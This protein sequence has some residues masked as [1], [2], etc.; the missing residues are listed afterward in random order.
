MFN[1]LKIKHYFC[2]NFK[3]QN[4]SNPKFLIFVALLFCSLL[5]HSQILVLKTKQTPPFKINETIMI[6]AYLQNNTSKPIIYYESKYFETECVKES[7]K[8]FV[9]GQ[10]VELYKFYDGYDKS[11]FESYINTLQPGLKVPLRFKQIPLKS[12]G[13]YVIEYT[14]M[15]SPDLIVKSYAKT[16]AAYEKSRRITPFDIYGKFEFDVM[17]NKY[18]SLNDSAQLSYSNWLSLKKDKDFIEEKSYYSMDSAVLH[19]DNVFI[20]TIN[21]KSPNDSILKKIGTFKNLK[22]L[23][24]YFNGQI[25]IPDEIY[26]LNLFELTVQTSKTDSIEFSEKISELDSLRYLHI[27]NVQN[28]PEN[29]TNLPNL[30]LLEIAFCKIDS[31]PGLERF[32]KLKE[33]SFTNLNLKT[34]EGLGLEK[35]PTLE[36]VSFIGNEELESMLPL[37]KCTNL[38]SVCFARCGIKEV[39]PEIENLKLLRELKL[40][41]NKLTK[42]DPNIGNLKNLEY[43]DFIY[44]P[45]L[46]ILPESLYEI[47]ALKVLIIDKTKVTRKLIK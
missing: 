8:M 40:G 30:S 2:Y 10:Q 18:D 23:T 42:V 24:L 25:R 28:F 45:D 43:V 14:H 4:M 44:N 12:P 35:I 38:R 22:S 37:L 1:L 9:N 46:A 19:P 31:F 32:K 13:H 17:G 15:Q 6:E 21:S 33:I 16:N 5:L 36:S 27:N 26:N 47:E 3:L 34:I 7:M 29:I 41:M 20:L 39:P 11:F